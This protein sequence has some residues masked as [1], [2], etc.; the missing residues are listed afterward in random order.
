M[1]S[2]DEKINLLHQKLEHIQQMGGEKQVERQ[3][4][5]G[6]LTARERLHLLFDENSF[7]ETG[8]LRKHNCHYFGQEK[9]DIP[10]DGVVTGYGTV[11][12]RLVFAFAQDFMSAAAPLGKPMRQRLLNCRKWP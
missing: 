12:G 5:R 6:K 7:V 9:K 2:V 11:D 10:A 4:S 8:A 3:H 1:A